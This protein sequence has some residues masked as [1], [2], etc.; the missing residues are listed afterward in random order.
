MF[1][2]VLKDYCCSKQILVLNVLGVFGELNKI[3]QNGVMVLYCRL[4]SEIVQRYTVIL[5]YTGLVFES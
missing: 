4:R 5:H 1:F 3:C 2:V